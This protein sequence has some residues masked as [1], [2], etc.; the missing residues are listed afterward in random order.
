MTRREIIMQTLWN[1]ELFLAG[2]PKGSTCGTCRW[3][4]DANECLAAP[5]STEPYAV[6]NDTP[7]CRHWR[8][9]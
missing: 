3:K 6:S 4:S 8:E 9:K 1:I 7:C 5:P 2:P